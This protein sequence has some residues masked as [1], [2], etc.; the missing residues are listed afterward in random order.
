MIRPAASASMSRLEC[1]RQA[2]A[3]IR[4]VSFTLSTLEPLSPVTS[5]HSGTMPMVVAVDFAL[6]CHPPGGSRLAKN[7]GRWPFSST[8]MARGPSMSTIS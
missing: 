6:K 7:E 2:G 4:L 3:F 5:T 8:W 1:T